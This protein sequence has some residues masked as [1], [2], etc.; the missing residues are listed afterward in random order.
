MELYIGGIGQGKTTYVIEKHKSENMRILD[1]GA[2]DDPE[3]IQ[4][5]ETV[6][7][8][9]GFHR[10]VRDRAEES[11]PDWFAGWLEAIPMIRRLME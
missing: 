8:L 11:E 9:N 10:M 1:A 4:C 7:I 6:L 3:K 5:S 2:Y